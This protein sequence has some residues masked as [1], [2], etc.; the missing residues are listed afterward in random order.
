MLEDLPVELI[1]G[2]LRGASFADILNLS[3]TSSYFRCISFTHRPLWID[4]SDSYRIRL[5]LGETLKTT[6]LSQ[7]PRHAARS[8]SVLYKWRHHH[9][10]GRPISPIRTYEAIR[11]YDLPSWAF[12]SPLKYSQRSFVGHVPP[13]FINVLPGG[14]SFLFGSMGHLGIYDLRGEYGCEL[15]VPCCPRFDPRAGDT[16][17]T[18]DWNSSDNGAHIGVAVLS[19]AFNDMRDIETYLSVFRVKYSTSAK[20]P[21]I[22]RTHVFALPINATAVTMKGHLILVRGSN[23]FLLLDLQASQRGWWHLHDSEI[24]FSTIQNA[25]QTISLVVNSRKDNS[26][27]LQTIDIPPAMEPFAHTSTPFWSS[28]R[29]SPSTVCALP[30]SKISPSPAYLTTNSLDAN[31]TTFREM[32]LT[33]DARTAVI[34]S[35]RLSSVRNVYAPETVAHTVAQPLEPLRSSYHLVLAAVGAG[36]LA[37]LRADDGCRKAGD[38]RKFLTLSFPAEAM[39]GVGRTVAFDDVYGIGIAFARGDFTS[40]LEIVAPS[41]VTSPGTIQINVTGQALD[42]ASGKPTEPGY[43]F[44]NTADGQT[45]DG[46]LEP[47]TSKAIDNNT[48]LVSIQIPSMPKGGGWVVQARVGFG[49]YTVVATSNTFSVQ[50]NF[51]SPDFSKQNGIDNKHNSGLSSMP[52]PTLKLAIGAIIFGSLAFGSEILYI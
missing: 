2:L 50:S 48:T 52:R 25:Q 46:V 14:R 36:M 40:A 28:Y 4:A 17:A 45:Y 13:T 1:L 37:V 47:P 38:A 49:G 30:V 16:A 32:V 51:S 22:R 21:S 8:A 41:Q 34:S 39:P 12:W 23:D 27:S 26:R 29:F 18:L 20:V 3:R 35:T 6:D 33:M 44:Y 31:G 7:L 11:L 24:T 5:P 9:D 19:K 15:E 43:S 42:P 10:P